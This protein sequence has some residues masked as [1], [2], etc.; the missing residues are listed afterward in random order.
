MS[1]S[2]FE[3]AQIFCTFCDKAQNRVHCLIAGPNL[4]ICSECVVAFTHPLVTA[5][6][7]ED[8]GEKCNFCGKSCS[9]VLKMIHV[10]QSNICSGCLKICVEIIET[11]A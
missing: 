1:D 7:T 10:K 9:Q 6:K 8:A 3:I 2:R 5:P 4:Y 11:Q